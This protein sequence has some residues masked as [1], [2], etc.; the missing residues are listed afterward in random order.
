MS[1]VLQHTMLW[2]CWW[3]LPVLII[4]IAV[5]VGFAVKHQKMK[6][7]EKRLEDQLTELYADDTVPLEKDLS[8]Q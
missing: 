7:E 8:L 5:I 4:L 3:D 6:R 2:F 1:Y